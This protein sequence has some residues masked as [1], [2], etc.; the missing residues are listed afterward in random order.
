MGQHRVKEIG[1][2]SWGGLKTMEENH[3]HFCFPFSEMWVSLF[4]KNWSMS[5][6]RAM[7][8]ATTTFIEGRWCWWKL[9]QALHM[10]SCRQVLSGSCKGRK[11][12]PDFFFLL[13]QRIL[14]LEHTSGE[15]L[16]LPLLLLQSS[17]LTS[18]WRSGTCLHW[19]VWIQLV[20]SAAWVMNSPCKIPCQCSLQFLFTIVQSAGFS[21]CKGICRD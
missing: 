9:V 6:A 16:I 15:K 1:Y 3:W 17:W 13:W 4:Y 18:G 2:F 14:A 10:S 5:L 12:S 11:W 19:L 20:R 7:A 8:A 21:Q